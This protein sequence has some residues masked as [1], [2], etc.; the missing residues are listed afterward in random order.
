MFIFPFVN[1]RHAD[2]HVIIDEKVFPCHSVALE[3]VSEYFDNSMRDKETLRRIKLPE[4]DVPS[5][6]FPTL[7]DWILQDDHGRSSVINKGNVVAL[8]S[9]AKFLGISGK[10]ILMQYDVV[11]LYIRLQYFRTQIT[12]CRLPTRESGN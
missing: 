11:M 5:E 2:T 9:C 6:V 3:S 10:I 12:V 4:S 7:M 1:N 8:F